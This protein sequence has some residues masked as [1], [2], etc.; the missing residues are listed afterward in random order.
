M[1]VEGSAVELGEDIGCRVSANEREAPSGR[2]VDN[3]VGPIARETIGRL[4]QKRT[5]ELKKR[6]SQTVLGAGVRAES[7]R[8]GRCR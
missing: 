3:V 8:R 1:D 6:P 2:D 4:L 5:K 7:K